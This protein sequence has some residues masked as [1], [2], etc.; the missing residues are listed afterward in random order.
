MKVPTLPSYDA[1][2]RRGKGSKADSDCDDTHNLEVN[3]VN[4]TPFLL[5]LLQ[6]AGM[7]V[8]GENEVRNQL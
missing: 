1:G 7:V 8:E 4:S 6:I 3:L 2:E 5:S